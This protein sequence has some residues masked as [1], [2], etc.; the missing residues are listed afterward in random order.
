MARI[1]KPILCTI[2]RPRPEIVSAT[3]NF[4]QLTYKSRVFGKIEFNSYTFMA[5]RSIT[6]N[7]IAT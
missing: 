3:M 2:L 6:M 1:C 4:G 7:N 5:L